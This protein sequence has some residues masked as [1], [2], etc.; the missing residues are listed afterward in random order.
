MLLI[1]LPDIV[2]HVFTSFP[3]VTSSLTAPITGRQMA[4]ALKWQVVVQYIF[5][6]FHYFQKTKVCFGVLFIILCIY[7]IKLLCKKFISV[8]L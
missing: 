1:L 8:T 7:M 6:I 3:F 5:H 4:D 2:Q